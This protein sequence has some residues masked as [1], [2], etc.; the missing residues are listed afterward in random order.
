L[1][2]LIIARDVS[3][4]S[5]LDMGTKYKIRELYTKDEELLNETAGKLNYQTFIRVYEKLNK[6]IQIQEDFISSLDYKL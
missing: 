4:A 2:N 6:R 5:D 3:D 1:S